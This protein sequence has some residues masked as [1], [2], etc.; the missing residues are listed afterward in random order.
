MQT[1]KKILKCILMVNILFILVV[2]GLGYKNEAEKKNIK[3]VSNQIEAG[4]VENEETV[5]EKVI[6]V[7][8][9]VGVYVNT[10]GILVIDTGVVTDMEGNKKAPAKNKLMKGDYIKKLNG[11]LMKTK[12]QMIENI[13]DC[14]GKTLVFEVLRKNEMIEVR[15]E[16]V[17]TEKNIYKVG[18]WVRDDLQGLGTITYVDGTHFGALGHSINDTDTG[19]IL[20]ISGGEIYEADIM[21]VEKGVSGVPGEV[22]GMITYQTENVT[23][24]VD[25][26]KI[27]GI[28]GD[29]TEDFRKSIENEEALA[30]ADISEVTIG[31]AYIQSY[32]SGKKEL[33]EVNITDIHKNDNGDQEMQIIVTD[34]NLIALTGGI[35]QGMSGSPILQNGKLIGAVTHVFVEDPKKGYGIFVETMCDVSQ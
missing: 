8:K 6:P 1:Y 18:I 19:E 16:P 30:I 13:T 15:V 12:K 3:E 29:I 9:V 26:N 31:K 17:E 35:V 33:Y 34:D 28:F 5:Q 7:G 4:N 27:Y 10:D 25:K 20:R 21:G 2:A 11:E 23:G 32:I 22:K 14:D 24:S